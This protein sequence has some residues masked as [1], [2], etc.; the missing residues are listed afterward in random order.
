MG[1]LHKG[2]SIW[3]QSR[4]DPCPND[5][6]IHIQ[7]SCDWLSYR[8]CCRR[9][10]NVSKEATAQRCCQTLHGSKVNW[11]KVNRL[12]SRGTCPIAGDAVERQGSSG[13]SVGCGWHRFCLEEL[14]E[15]NDDPATWQVP[16]TTK[17][18]L[19]SVERTRQPW[20][21]V[22][23]GEGELWFQTRVDGNR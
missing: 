16:A 1:L 6:S 17:W 20:L 22:C 9:I 10:Q 18:V 2:L 5:T 4:L 19:A 3:V 12:K 11:R 14:H 15:P 23:R 7:G 13:C 21:A 8:S